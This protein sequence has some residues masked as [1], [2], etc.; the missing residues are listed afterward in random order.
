MGDPRLKMLVLALASRLHGEQYYLK[1]MEQYKWCLYEFRDITFYPSPVTE[2]PLGDIDYSRFD[3][4]TLLLLTGGTSRLAKRI[5]E[6]SGKPTIIVVHGKHNSLASGLS[7]RSWA[8]SK[9]YKV[10][11][12][13]SDQPSM[14]CKR[15]NPICRGL[16]AGNMIRN[17]RVLEI[18]GDGRV[19]RAAEEFMK[20]T[21]ARVSAVSFEK[22]REIGWGVEEHGLSQYINKVREKIDLSGV[23]RKVVIDTVRI[24]YALRKLVLDGV[25]NAVSIDCFPFVVKYKVTPCLAVAMLNSD[26]IPTACED[27]FYSLVLLAASLGLTGEPGWIANPSGFT[28]QGYVKLA[29]C[30]VAPTLGWGC[31]LVPHFETGYPYAVTCRL[32]HGR[33]VVARLSLDYRLLGIYK[34]KKIAS[35][36]REPGLCR[37]QLVVD[38]G[39]ANGDE[40]IKRALGNHHVAIPWKEW[41]PEALEVLAWYMGW[42]LEFYN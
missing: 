29:H 34:A 38:L 18:N 10:Y 13:Y 26:G 8:L 24:Y 21:G 1:L 12:V 20:A 9:G 30:T 5:I 6:R 41:L 16:Y 17:L 3:I 22:I 37:T 15:F 23:D 39:P 11:L 14:L 40:F 2:E 27:D 19:S 25:Y 42:R 4:I 31:M 35:G 28:E 32:K 36:L 7:A 33:Y